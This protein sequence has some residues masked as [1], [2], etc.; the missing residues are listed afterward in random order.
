MFRNAL[1]GAFVLLACAADAQTNERAYESLQFRVVTPGARA[2]AMGKTFIGIADDA[3][4]AA[5]NPAGLSNLLLPEASIEWSLADLQHTRMLTLQPL[6]TTSASS[7]VS[8]PSFASYVKPLSGPGW[9]QNIT[10]AGFYNSL[11]RYR[12]KFSVANFDLYDGRSLPNDQGGY[13]GLI[14]ASGITGGFAAAVAV[15][16]WLSVGAALTIQHLDLY[17]ESNTS[18]GSLPGELDFRSGSLTDDS[19][20]R[21]GGQFGVLLKPTRWLTVGGSYIAGTTFHL[22]TTISGTFYTDRNEPIGNRNVRQI[23]GIDTEPQTDYRNP[24]RFAAG[25]SARLGAHWTLLTD[26]G[27]VKYSQRITPNFIVVDWLGLRTNPLRPEFYFIDDATEWHSGA[28]YRFT[29]GGKVCAIR[30]GAFTDP[31]HQMR[32]DTAAARAA[33]VAPD[34]VRSQSVQ[35]NFSRDGTINPDIGGD[36]RGYTGGFGIVFG[37]RY[38]VD[39]ALSWSG[40][41]HEVVIS[42]VVRFPR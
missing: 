1:A 22:D 9:R 3:T 36:S 24:D 31:D 4:A 29:A 16:E 34:I 27:I 40:N 5:S 35:F 28:E 11:Q 23:P 2:V 20:T 38:Q 37:N 41:A 8:Y 12:E 33:G 18:D 39:A 10:L 17:G 30:F 6:R 21:P 42:S 32:F 26:I 25:V 14:D 19:D 13:W 7:F 15:N